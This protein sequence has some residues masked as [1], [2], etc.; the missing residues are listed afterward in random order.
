MKARNILSKDSRLKLGLK[1]RERLDLKDFV[2][3]IKRVPQ[4]K[5]DFC[6]KLGYQPLM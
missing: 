4:E 1:D 3:G 6:H 5:F 2:D